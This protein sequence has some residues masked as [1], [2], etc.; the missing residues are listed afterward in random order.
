RAVH[1]QRLDDR[2]V[3]R[4]DE[5]RRL[6]AMKLH[7]A[8]PHQ[9]GH[10]ADVVARLVYEQPD[11]RD[12]RRQPPRD[13]A[14]AIRIDETRA[15]RP[16]DEPERLRAGID[17]RSRVFSPR[18]AADFY[19]HAATNAPSASPGFAAVMNR[20]PIRNAR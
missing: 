10:A 8:E 2:P 18:D 6:V 12:E 9:T 19:E 4:R 11:R 5:F 13:G 3:E 1:R 15:A 20:S 16:E 17:R 7:R 14:R